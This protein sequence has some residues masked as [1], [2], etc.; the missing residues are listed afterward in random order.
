MKN[1]RAFGREVTGSKVLTDYFGDL[2][3]TREDFSMEQSNL[4]MR[5][6]RHAGLSENLL[7]ATIDEG[8]KENSNRFANA[9]V[10]SLLKQSHPVAEDEERAAEIMGD[11]FIPS[12]F[13]SFSKLGKNKTV[14]AIPFKEKT[15]EDCRED[16]ILF[17]GPYFERKSRVLENM[18][19]EGYS[20]W[21]VWNKDKYEKEFQKKL[22]SLREV[23]PYEWMLLSK[24]LQNK[25]VF[26]QYEIPSAAIIVYAA[27]SWFVYK[28]YHVHH[29]SVDSGKDFLFEGRRLQCKDAMIGVREYAGDMGSCTY[30]IGVWI[31]EDD[32]DT[33]QNYMEEK[34]GSEGTYARPRPKD[35]LGIDKPAYPVLRKPDLNI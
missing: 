7:Q 25:S 21:F 31:D 22:S 11:N 20:R 14:P 12:V 16:H 15:L 24:N 10:W 30:E 17:L 34:A 28:N 35:G 33:P 8:K 13:R 18:I 6:L 32:Y 4:F 9:V 27:K 3:R 5:A 29:L 19:F 2:G 23:V 26:P 1:S